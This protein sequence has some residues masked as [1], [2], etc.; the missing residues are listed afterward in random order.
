MLE[1]LAPAGGPWT[2]EANETNELLRRARGGDAAALEQPLRTL[3]P[4][5]QTAIRLQGL[6]PPGADAKRLLREAAAV[7]RANPALRAADPA[8]FMIALFTV[9][10]LGLSPGPEQLCYLGGRPLQDVPHDQHGSLAGG[11]VLQC[12]DEGRETHDCEEDL[13][14][15][16]VEDVA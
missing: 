1:H 11:Q 10:Q 3:T 4:D 12:R 2:S 13:G 6:M 7:V 14:E 15:G 8:S 5:E 9:G 16:G